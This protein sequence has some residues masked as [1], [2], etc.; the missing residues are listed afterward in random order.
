MKKTALLALILLFL[1]TSCAPGRA[2]APQDAGSIVPTATFSPATA[3]AEPTA[4]PSPTTVS[5]AAPTVEFTSSPPATCSI[6]PLIPEVDPAKN[7]LPPVEESDWVFGAP[8]PAVTIVSYCNYQ[9]TACNSLNASL[10]ELQQQYPESLGIVL[11][12]YPQPELYDKSLLAAYAAEAAG[13][14]NDFWEMNDLLYSR[15][16]EWLGRSAEDFKNWLLEKSPAYN[17]DPV[18]LLANMESAQVAERV[19]RVVNDAAALSISNTPVLF[20]NDLMV[21]TRVTSSSLAALV[22]FFLLPESAFTACPPMT[23]DP[24]KEYLATFET[25][26]GNIVFELFP[27]VAPVAVNSFVFLAQE[28]WYDDTTFFRVIPGFIVQ[29]GD[30]SESGLGGP[31]YIFS[32]EVDP[33]LRFDAPGI[34]AMTH[35]SGDMNGS[36]FFITYTALPELDGQFTIIGRVVDGMNVLNSLRPRNPETDEILLPADRL[37]AVTIEEK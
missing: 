34:L 17:I 11:R 37:I 28:G 21:K 24:E 25:E 30:P 29:G 16:S 33:A 36:Q 13:V 32:N 9:R 35:T 20:F 6:E 8:E 27:G 15:Q 2:T 22:D 4:T 7:N 14:E 19:N 1:F 10:L 31:G 26:K 12:Q 3:T 18:Q 23:I 5:A